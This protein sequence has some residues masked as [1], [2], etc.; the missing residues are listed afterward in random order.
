MLERRYSYPW[1]TLRL[2]SLGGCSAQG[3]TK[4][5]LVSCSNLE[6]CKQLSYELRV[7]SQRLG[8][9]SLNLAIETRRAMAARRGRFNLDFEK[10]SLRTGP[11]SG[12]AAV[13]HVPVK[14]PVA[15]G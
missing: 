11:V 9:L 7:S 3:D 6:F 4:G 10:L 1:G 14:L 13:P 2:R 5:H 15:M 12:D 8:S